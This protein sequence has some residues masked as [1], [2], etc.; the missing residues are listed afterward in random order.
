[1]TYVTDERQAVRNVELARDADADGVFLVNHG[2]SLDR[3]LEIAGNIA[4]SQPGLFLGLNCF[5]LAAQDVVRRAPSGV[6]AVWANE[7]LV[8]ATTESTAASVRRAREASG[9]DGLF[10]ATLATLSGPHD[11]L[12]QS[13]AGADQIDVLTIVGHGFEQPSRLEQ[14]RG[15]SG[16]LGDRPVAVASA[17]SSTHVDRLLP[18]VD[19]IMTTART[20]NGLESLD[21]GEAQRL[22]ARIHAHEGRRLTG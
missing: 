21:F 2:N 5:D 10:F 13:L 14:M 18:H 9:W 4:A 6:A 17:I 7:P 22:A 15:V 19:C 8:P 12:R 3:L 11:A 16:A 1:V 20:N